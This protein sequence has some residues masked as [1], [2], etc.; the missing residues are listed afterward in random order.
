MSQPTNREPN[1]FEAEGQNQKDGP[2]RIFDVLEMIFIN[3]VRLSC[4]L[5]F[6]NETFYSLGD[7]VGTLSKKGSIQIR[8]NVKAAMLGDP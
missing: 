6:V 8:Y 3:V 5:V 7:V 1:A 4:D 2:L